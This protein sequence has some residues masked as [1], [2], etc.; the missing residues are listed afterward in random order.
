MTQ[1]TSELAV[2]ARN[3]AHAKVW[4]VHASTDAAWSTALAEHLSRAGHKARAVGIS[5]AIRHIAWD[6]VGG[7]LEGLRKLLPSMGSGDQTSVMD[8]LSAR[9]P[10]VVITRSADSG[11]AFTRLRTLI[12]AKFSIL[13]FVNDFELTSAWTSS[14]PDLVVAPT[15]GQ[16]THINF[17]FED[18]TRVGIAGPLAPFDVPSSDVRSTARAAMKLEGE[19]CAVLIDGSGMRTSDIPLVVSQLAQLGEEDST[20]RWLFYYGEHADNG[21]SMRAAARTHGI[22]ALMFSNT[23]PLHRVLPGIDRVIS[24]AR[25]TTRVEC[26]YLK[27]PMLA[28]GD[29][30]QTHPLVQLGVMA[31]VPNVHAVA[32]GFRQIEEGEPLP[33][34]HDKLPEAFVQ[35]VVFNTIERL[36]GQNIED[37]NIDETER[38]GDRTALHFEEIGAPIRV[39]DAENVGARATRELLSP[40]KARE[41]MTGLL[42]ELRR[43]E[44]TQAEAVE[45][46]DEWMERL[47]DAEDAGESEL[48]DFAEKRARSEMEQVAQ[49]Q[50]AIARVQDARNELRKQ[51]AGKQTQADMPKESIDDVPPEMEAKFQALAD[52][53][54][55]RALR[56]RA[57]KK[58]PSA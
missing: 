16:I 35:S 54:R 20:R 26:A 34:V 14:A 40:Q 21:S 31:A 38:A 33:S 36:V 28:Y 7:G 52:Q 8:E 4:V 18:D 53:R 43:L 25:S 41:E 51:H 13:A 49:L 45:R 46:R 15:R 24:A 57:G 29:H 48:R 39:A 5:D 56:Q 17:D 55:L 2:K 10:R 19:Q 37:R 6:R 9:P 58:D 50:R 27:I 47:Q 30:L 23:T 12:G 22:R 42:M 44:Q 3:T 11:R 1:S 32:S